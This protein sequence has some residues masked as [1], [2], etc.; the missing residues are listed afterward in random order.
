MIYFSPE[1]IKVQIQWYLFSCQLWFTKTISYPLK[2]SQINFSVPRDHLESDLSTKP[3]SLW[4]TDDGFLTGDL[5]MLL[6]SCSPLC[7]DPYTGWDFVSNNK[8]YSALFGKLS[9]RYFLCPNFNCIGFNCVLLCIYYIWAII[10]HVSDKQNS[11]RAHY[12][13][14]YGRMLIQAFLSLVSKTVSISILTVKLIYVCFC[15]LF[16]N[17]S[18]KFC[19]FSSYLNIKGH[20]SQRCKMLWI[21][22]NITCNCNIVLL[23]VFPVIGLLI[24]EPKITAEL[25]A[26]MVHN[27]DKSWYK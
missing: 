25:C 11:C 13:H 12:N 6:P 18:I 3:G 2:E 27:K 10:F 1:T 23:I 26:A 19:K 24:V 5:Q 20:A 16:I 22:I 15:A 8:K 14:L 4:L 21:I 9:Y 17:Y 7:L